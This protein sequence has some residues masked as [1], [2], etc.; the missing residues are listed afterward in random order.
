MNLKKLLLLASIGSAF[1]FSGVAFSS[2]EVQSVQTKDV[3]V[4]PDKK[5]AKGTVTPHS[6]PR[7]AKGMIVPK[8]T[9]SKDEVAKPVDEP[10]KS[11]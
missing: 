5:P 8:K 4:E 6:H 11:Q 2:D 3:K 7:D 1:V 9:D 10:K